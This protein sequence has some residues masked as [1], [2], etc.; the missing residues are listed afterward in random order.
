MKACCNAEPAVVGRADF[1][2]SHDTFLVYGGGRYAYRLEY[3]VKT[4]AT[5][6]TVKEDGGYFMVPVTYPK[7][8]VQESFR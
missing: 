2:A 6:K 4:G 1:L 3:F 7:K 5:V 8:T